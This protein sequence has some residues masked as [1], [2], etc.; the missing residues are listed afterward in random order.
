MIILWIWIII[1]YL[2]RFDSTILHLIESINDTTFDIIDKI[3][4]PFNRKKIHINYDLYWDL[5]K[6]YNNE[7]NYIK[8][9]ELYELYD[10]YLFYKNECEK[11]K[12]INLVFCGACIYFCIYIL[13][14]N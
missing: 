1:T 14:Y 6:R 10:D 3:L 2:T 13:F 7:S 5:V 9:T 8:D 11:L 12:S 4:T